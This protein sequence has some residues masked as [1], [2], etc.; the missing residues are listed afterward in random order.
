MKI[1][2]GVKRGM[3]RFSRET[4]HL[5]TSPYVEYYRVYEIESDEVLV[6]NYLAVGEVALQRAVETIKAFS[7][8]NG[9]RLQEGD[10][11]VIRPV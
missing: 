3:D 4:Y 5:V 10:D 7:H 11:G 6:G 1:Q 8:A 9:L 2:I